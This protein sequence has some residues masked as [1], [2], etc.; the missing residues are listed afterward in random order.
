MDVIYR[1]R[2]CAKQLNDSKSIGFCQRRKSLNVHLR[3]S[4]YTNIRVNEYIEAAKSLW[5]ARETRHNARKVLP[6]DLNVIRMSPRFAS[7]MFEGP[8]PARIVPS[9]LLDDK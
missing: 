9:G 5:A 7:R 4:T 8:A 1:P 3:I 6:A 2:S